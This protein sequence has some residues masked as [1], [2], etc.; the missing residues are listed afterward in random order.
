MIALAAV[1]LAFGAGAQQDGHS[2]YVGL[3]LGGGLNTMAFSPENGDHSL[4]LGFDAG[5]HYTHFF[6]SHWGLGFGVHYTYANAYATYDF[7]EVTTGLTHADNPSIHYNLTT[8]F[9]NWKERQTVGVLGIPVEAFYRTAL[10]DKWSFI[11]GLGVQFDLPLH[12]KYSASEG[13]YTTTGVF[14]ALGS[15]VVSDMPEHGFST[16]D[17]AFDSKIDNLSSVVV[18]V[19]ADAGVRYALGNNWGLYLGLYASYGL[20]DMLGEKSDDIL[21][22]I[23]AT[24]PSQLDYHGTYGS[25]EISSLNLVRAGVKV[26]IDLGWNCRDREAERIAAE[27]ALRQARL[28]AIEDSVADAYRMA[29]KQEAREKA[30]AERLAKKAARE[31]AEAERQAAKKESREKAEA[32]R[33]AKK[34]AAEKAKAQKNY[35][36]TVYFASAGTKPQIDAQTDATLHAIGEAMKADKSLKATIYGH[37][38]S[39]GSMQT[40]MRYGQQRAEALKAYLVKLGAPAKNIKCKSKG[41][42]EPAADN[43]T[44]EG[45]AK[46]RRATV[47]LK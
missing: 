4:G 28:K 5:L 10:S 24:D 26:G 37:T 25:N 14:P 47:E 22:V 38:D 42:K 17:A 29:A 46:N 23:N 16:Y 45:R 6:G 32:E 2:N 41:P 31:K 12:G 20:T 30:E 44:K 18:S 40:N 36:A 15:Y 7:D 39:L 21:L 33:Q 35:S 19:I 13:D 3:N 34:D 9:N 8:S 1:A 27:E 43:K 11:G